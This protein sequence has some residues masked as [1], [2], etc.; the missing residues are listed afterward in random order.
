MQFCISKA[1]FS[2]DAVFF[3]CNAVVLVLMAHCAQCTHALPCHC[4]PFSR[5]RCTAAYSHVLVCMSLMRILI[6]LSEKGGLASLHHYRTLSTSKGDA[7]I[8]RTDIKQHYYNRF[9]LILPSCKLLQVRLAP[10]AVKIPH[11]RHN[12]L[13]NLNALYTKKLLFSLHFTPVSLLHL[14][15]VDTV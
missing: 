1:A 14:P 6:S 11:P 10:L 4:H 3:L 8:G 2:R 7:P 13:A 12:E 5:W 15:F 9:F